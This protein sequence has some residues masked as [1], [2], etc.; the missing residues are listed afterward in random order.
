MRSAMEHSFSSP[1]V[2]AHARGQAVGTTGTRPTLGEPRSGGSGCCGST[3][4]TCV[5]RASAAARARRTSPLRL[6]AP[7][8]D[9][10]PHRQVREHLGRAADVVRV[11]VG[12]PEHVDRRAAEVGLQPVEQV[13]VGSRAHVAAP[14]AAWLVGGVDKD[15][16][17]VGQVDQHG[18]G[19]PH[20]VEVQG[21]G[22]P[23]G[24]RDVGR[25]RGARGRGRGGGRAHGPRGKAGLG[26]RR[27]PRAGER[28]QKPRDSNA[29]RPDDGP[30]LRREPTGAGQGGPT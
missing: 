2:P 25:A 30:H 16:T 5:P 29:G 20:V 1:P 6:V 13:G 9:V 3:T 8:V 24:A 14:L 12:D 17:A 19:L 7:V 4:A 18:Q 23:R 26:Q 22:A 11:L 27:R 21:H 10:E 15:V 28:E